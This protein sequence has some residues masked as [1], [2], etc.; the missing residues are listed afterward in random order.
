MVQVERWYDPNKPPSK[1]AMLVHQM[2]A[3]QNT[4][5]SPIDAAADMLS[6]ADFYWLSDIQYGARSPAHLSAALVG[7][8]AEI[9]EDPCSPQRVIGI[10]IEDKGEVRP[11]SQKDPRVLRLNWPQYIDRRIVVVAPGWRTTMVMADII[12]QLSAHYGFLNVWDEVME[13]IECLVPGYIQQ[14]INEL[15]SDRLQVLRG[16]LWNWVNRKEVK[17]LYEEKDSRFSVSPRIR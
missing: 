2:R 1:E 6:T 7:E 16:N 11:T 3:L 9:F 13:V 15:R 17:W 5:M 12:A 10:H 8:A 4:D 14:V